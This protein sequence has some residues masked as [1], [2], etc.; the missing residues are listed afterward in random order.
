M[1]DFR[2]ILKCQISR[3]SSSNESRV[4]RSGLT[5]GRTDTHDEAD[6]RFSQ[7]LD[8][9]YKFYILRTKGIP[10]CAEWLSEKTAIISLYSFK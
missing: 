5:D 1:T 10:V 4:V 8:R 7:F 9:A 6:S 2:K 3:R